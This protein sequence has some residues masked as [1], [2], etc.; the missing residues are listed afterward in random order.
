MPLWPTSIIPRASI[1][2]TQAV[3]QQLLF[4]HCQPVHGFGLHICP[5]KLA[6][7]QLMFSDFL[8]LL[9]SS[10]HT[11]DFLPARDLRTLNEVS[12]M[13]ESTEFTTVSSLSSRFSK[14][15]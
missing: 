12:L 15:V 14:Y 1:L 3:L 5:G 9:P 6:E 8:T 7:P 10:S 13:A 2:L 11:L 4:Q